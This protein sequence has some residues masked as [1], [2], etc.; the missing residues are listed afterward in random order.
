MTIRFAPDLD[1]DLD[2]ADGS[3]SGIHDMTDAGIAASGAEAPRGGVVLEGPASR[4]E[5]TSDM[6]EQGGHFDLAM[7]RLPSG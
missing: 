1:R 2:D 5:I 6:R 3:Y 7:H 4:R